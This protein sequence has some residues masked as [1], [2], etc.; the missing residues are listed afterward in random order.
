ML[1]QWL[2]HSCHRN[3]G[4]EKLLQE[5]RLASLETGPERELAV[6]RTEITEMFSSSQK[7]ST[8]LPTC[9]CSNLSFS[10]CFMPDL[11]R[12]ASLYVIRVLICKMGK[13]TSTL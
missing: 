8:H 5:G 7:S 3:G 9:L 12:K 6:Y 4:R 2:P 13:A 11:E 10:D 1:L